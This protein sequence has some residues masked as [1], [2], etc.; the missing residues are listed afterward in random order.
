VIPETV[1]AAGF[2]DFSAQIKS[3]TSGC[4]AVLIASVDRAPN[5]ISEQYKKSG[6]KL[7]S[8]QADQPS[9]RSI[10]HRFAIAS[11]GEISVHEYSASL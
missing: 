7:P 4:D 11:I 1:G 9:K 8:S 10:S 2:E 3:N 6:L 5:I